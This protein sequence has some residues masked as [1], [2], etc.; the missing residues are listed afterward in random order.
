M[1]DFKPLK[2]YI[3]SEV[4]NELMDVCIKYQINTPLRLCH[5]LA[6]CAHESGNFKHVSENLNYSLE[7]LM[8]VFPK[9]FNIENVES[10]VHQPV[11]IAARVYA[12]RMGNGDEASLEGW[13]YRG[14]GYIQLTGKNNYAKFDAD[15]PENI[16]I[17]PEIV[18]EKYPL[19]SA[20]WFWHENKLNDIADQGADQN[21]IAAVTKKINGSYL[22]LESRIDHF[23]KFYNAL[24]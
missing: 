2:D 17:N 22:G 20:G 23:N 6:Q 13:L 1:I 21:V 14:R 8:R 18:A 24:L 5:F 16:L 3:P 7:A 12:N 9:Y 10:Y 19:L 15:V 4:Y 11:E